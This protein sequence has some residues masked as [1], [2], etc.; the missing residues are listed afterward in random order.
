[1]VWFWTWVLTRLRRKIQPQKMPTTNPMTQILQNKCPLFLIMQTSSTRQKQINGKLFSRRIPWKP[2][3]TEM[4]RPASMEIGYIA[5]IYG[6]KEKHP[7]SSIICS[8]WLIPNNM[9][10]KGYLEFDYSWKI[11]GLSQAWHVTIKHKS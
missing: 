8:I 3:P 9:L 2:S 5:D 1:M 7:T 4:T 11:L 6:H 10:P